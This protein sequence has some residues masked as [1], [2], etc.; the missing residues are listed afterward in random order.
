MVM[1][2]M[3]MI[4]KTGRMEMIKMGCTDGLMI[5]GFLPV[6]DRLAMVED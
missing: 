5:D 6:S 2:Q 4:K 1:I 3:V